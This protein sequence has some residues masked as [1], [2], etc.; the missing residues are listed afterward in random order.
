MI[1]APKLRDPNFLETVLLMVRHDSEGAMGLVLN[2]PLGVTVQEA[3]G[4]ET[5]LLLP[6]LPLFRGGPCDSPLMVLHDRE[7]DGESI[8]PGVRF[9]TEAGE[10]F[11]VLQGAGL[12]KCFAGYSGWSPGQ[13]E[14]EMASDAWM[15]VD[16]QPAQVFSTKPELYRKL[17]T[18]VSLSTWVDP[19]QI[20]QDPSLN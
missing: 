7:T 6:E 10:I 16:P 1:S 13:L 12:S 18:Q 4:N 8:L 17:V 9:S 5:A 11:S 2:R 20:P 14:S 15:M 19:A 3:C